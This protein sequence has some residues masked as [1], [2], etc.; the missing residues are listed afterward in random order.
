MVMMSN[1]NNNIFLFHFD[2]KD[3]DLTTRSV[4]TGMGYKT[5]PDDYIV[6]AIEKQLKEIGNILELSGGFK[7]MN[8]EDFSCGND[9]FEIEDIKF[10][11]GKIIA[12]QLKKAENIAVFAATAGA[13]IERYMAEF[14][15]Q[16]DVFSAY[17]LDAIGSEAAELITEET[18]NKVEKTISSI[19]WKITNRYSPGY[20]GW[21]VAEQEKLFAFLPESFLNIALSESSLMTPIKSVSGIIGLGPSVKKNGYT[22]SICNLETCFRRKTNG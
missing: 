8:P 2:I 10:D 20:C 14:K 5:A 12:T 7:I 16:G 21:S 22:C 6:S 17:I 13:E 11:C 9:Y 1:I 3:I 4:L 19:K 15:K 18:Q